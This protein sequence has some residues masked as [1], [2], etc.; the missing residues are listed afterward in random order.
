MDNNR[1]AHLQMLQNVISRMASNSSMFKGW[2]VT[3]V[4]AAFALAAKDAEQ[5]YLLVAYV[6]TAMFWVVDAYYLRVERQFCD[7]YEAVASSKEEVDFKMD[8]SELPQSVVSA[9]VGSINAVFYGVML[10][11]VVLTQLVVTGG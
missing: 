1:V 2:A 5:R 8:P 6:P 9:F 10:S 4:A 3:L 7:L 11:I